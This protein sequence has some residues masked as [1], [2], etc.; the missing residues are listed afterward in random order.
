MITPLLSPRGSPRGSLTNMKKCSIGLSSPKN[1]IEVG[2]QQ[3]IKF[4]FHNLG[5]TGSNQKAEKMNMNIKRSLQ[6]EVGKKGVSGGHGQRA[7]SNCNDG[8]MNREIMYNM[9][10][11]S[12]TQSQSVK[13]TNHQLFLLKS[14]TV[15]QGGHKKE[16]GFSGC[17]LLERPSIQHTIEKKTISEY[18]GTF[19]IFQSGDC[20]GVGTVGGSNVKHNNI[21]DKKHNNMIETNMKH[22]LESM[23]GTMP[24][25]T[26]QRLLPVKYGG[27]DSQ[28][29]AYLESRRYTGG[30]YPASASPRDSTNM[31]IS[32][33]GKSPRGIRKS[34]QEAVEKKRGSSPAQPILTK[35]EKHYMLS[36]RAS[37]PF[38]LLHGGGHQGGA[39]VI[40]STHVLIQQSVQ[41]VIQPSTHITAPGSPPITQDPPINSPISHNTRSHTPNKNINENNEV[42]EFVDGLNPR[43]AQYII[44]DLERVLQNKEKDKDNQM[45]TESHHLLK[46]IHNL[47]GNNCKQKNPLPSY[48][49]STNNMNE[50]NHIIVDEAKSPPLDKAKELYLLK[51]E[52]KPSELELVHRTR[53]PGPQ[54]TTN[55]I[56]TDSFK[57]IL[58]IYTYNI[59]IENK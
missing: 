47:I 54:S 32:L 29:H 26:T 51:D 50:N 7:N 57:Y 41:P 52:N 13:P 19:N 28:T 24:V 8:N 21:Q 42:S 20:E 10:M 45:E 46:K 25:Y 55:V 43:L 1:S 3:H 40:Q 2:V 49:K 38:N 12:H 27:G 22:P 23:G 35:G 34:K 59:Y 30:E 11:N 15:K 14:P 6:L 39:Q 37:P 9:N 31:V 5:K 58:Y 48:K 18:A 53:N 33:K 44:M 56:F 17:N 4:D 36:G 16:G